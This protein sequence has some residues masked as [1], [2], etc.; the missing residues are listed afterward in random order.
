M[1]SM[2]D[3]HEREAVLLLASET[4][5]GPV[6]RRAAQQEIDGLRTEW[7]ELFNNYSDAM[8]RYTFALQQDRAPREHL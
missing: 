4:N 6:P 1:K 2:R 8:A 3:L 5:V 7:T